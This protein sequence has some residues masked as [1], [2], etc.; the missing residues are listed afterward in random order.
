MKIKSFLGVLILSTIALLQSSV[1]AQ[2]QRDWAGFHVYAADN[3]RLDS[4]HAKVQVVFYGNS[5][6]QIW[7]EIRPHFFTDNGFTGRGIGG[8]TS[9]ELLVRMRQD[10]INLHPHT[11][12]IM[13]GVNDIAQN[14]GPISLQHTVGNIIS[15]C[16]LAK[17]NGIRPVL[18]SPLPAR[19][20]YWNPSITDAPQQIQMLN[21]L[22]ASYAH[23]QNILYV[24]YY[25]AMV[26][27]DGGLKKGLSDD[28]VHPN[29]AGYQIMEPIILKALGRYHNPTKI[30]KESL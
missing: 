13:C 14:N 5:I 9:S 1:Y 23:E 25:S 30:L 28:E 17:A 3:A 20:F 2:A 24:D 29:H 12:V 6:T 8:Q 10:V 18:C 11:V 15:M 4:L 19:S 21:A 26:D 27:T 22:I 16:E 7:N